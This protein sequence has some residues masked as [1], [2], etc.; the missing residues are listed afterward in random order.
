MGT[1]FWS[2]AQGSANEDVPTREW[3]SIRAFYFDSEATVA[4][5]KHT[6]WSVQ[7]AQ[8]R[9]CVCSF[10]YSFPAIMLPQAFTRSYASDQNG[11][12]RIS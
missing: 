11:S 12:S 9:V 7:C 2:L 6:D 4:K 1:A 10:G 8:Y 3:T 5:K